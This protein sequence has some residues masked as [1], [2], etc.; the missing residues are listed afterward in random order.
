VRRFVS[1]PQPCILFGA[2]ASTG[3]ALIPDCPEEY[4]DA[5]PRA[6]KVRIHLYA[7]CERCFSMP[8]RRRAKR[9]ERELRSNRR[10]PVL[11]PNDGNFLVPGD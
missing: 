3:A 11:D 4:S 5:P 2:R 1:V 6:N 7:L 10:L 9:I 8:A